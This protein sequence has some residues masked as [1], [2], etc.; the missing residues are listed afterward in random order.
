[1]YWACAFQHC[2]D[3]SSLQD[4]PVALPLFLLRLAY[5]NADHPNLPLNPLLE[6]IF[7]GISMGGSW[8]WTY[9]QSVFRHVRTQS[10]SIQTMVAGLSWLPYLIELD[11]SSS[12]TCSI[13][14]M[15]CTFCWCPNF[16]CH[17]LPKRTE[18]GAPPGRTVMN[19]DTVR[20]Q[21][22]I[23]PDMAGKLKRWQWQ[24]HTFRAAHNFERSPAIQ[25]K[26]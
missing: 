11:F 25:R 4:C 17:I 22:V 8:H 15:L 12:F 13:Q 18:Q 21:P 9:V 7:R 10:L 24:C 23:L 2:F 14:Y 5:A 1:M 20:V 6:G 26:L 16:F 3:A 19:C